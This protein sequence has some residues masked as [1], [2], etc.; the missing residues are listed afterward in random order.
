M[1]EKSDFVYRFY[2]SPWSKNRVSLVGTYNDG[3][4]K[5]AASRCSNNDNFCKKTGRT[6]AERRLA[7]NN[8]VAEFHLKECSIATFVRVVEPLAWTIAN[9]AHLVHD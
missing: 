7:D 5:V 9:N 2:T 8:L 1:G 6:I 4:L 3:V